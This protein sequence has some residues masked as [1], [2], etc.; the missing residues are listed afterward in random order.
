M[1]ICFTCIACWITKATNLGYC[2]P[3]VTMV[4]REGLNVNVIYT[5]PVLFINTDC[6]NWRMGTENKCRD[7]VQARGQGRAV[8]LKTC[9]T[10]KADKLHVPKVMH[11]VLRRA[12]KNQL[13]KA[14]YER[15]RYSKVT[16]LATCDATDL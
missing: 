14:S 15:K 13:Q 8:R 12:F 7:I 2:F 5:L 4:A 9:C 6:K 11:T 1:T 3:T 10:T 16:F